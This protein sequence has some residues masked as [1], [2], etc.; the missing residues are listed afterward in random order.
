MAMPTTGP[1]HHLPRMVENIYRYVKF[2]I[3]LTQDQKTESSH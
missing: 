1:M 3:M 2:I